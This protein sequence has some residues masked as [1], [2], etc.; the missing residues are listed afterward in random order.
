[1]LDDNNFNNPVRIVRVDL[2]NGSDK[3]FEEFI[4]EEVLNLLK[5][6]IKNGGRSKCSTNSSTET[7]EK[8]EKISFDFKMTNCNQ[9]LK[10]LTQKLKKSKHKN[11]GLLLYGI[12]GSGK[13]YYGQYL[14]QE[15]HMPFIKKRASDLM[16]KYVGETEQ[17]IAAA[18]EEAREKKAVLLL[19]E[20]D[21]FLFDRRYADRDFEAAHVNEMLTQMESHQYPFI[22]TTN[23]KDKIDPASMRRFV[24]KISFEYMNKENIKAGLKTYFGKNIKF[25]D[26]QYQKLE[27]LTAGDFKIAKRKLDILE[28]SKY[29][30]QNVFEYLLAEQNE[31]GLNKGSMA[32]N[33]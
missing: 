6:D 11:Y 3:D 9:D 2:I 14:A 16:A 22:M 17:N 18:F 4:P 28:D 8:Q 25:T 30:S 13:S 15:L 24:F 32:I 12:S 1:M 23:L 33:L 29:T 27:Y 19:D 20:A 21:S 5:R 31:K 7:E 10:I 26:D